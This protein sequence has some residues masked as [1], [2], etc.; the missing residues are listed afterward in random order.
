MQGI[1]V[2]QN[3]FKIKGRGLIIS[4]FLK[5]GVLKTGMVVEINKQKIPLLGVE[6]FNKKVEEVRE[7]DV[8]AKTL[9]IVLPETAEKNIENYINQELIFKGD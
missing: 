6:A 2:P 3:I 9:G 1:F 8:A 7:M 4:G 5:S